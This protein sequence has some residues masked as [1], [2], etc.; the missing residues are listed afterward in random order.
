MSAFLTELHAETTSVFSQ[1]GTQFEEAREST[2]AL[3]L[4]LRIP[5]GL[6]TDGARSPLLLSPWGPVYM[7]YSLTVTNMMRK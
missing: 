6:H 4:A 5:S 1:S 3:E 2:A 7:L